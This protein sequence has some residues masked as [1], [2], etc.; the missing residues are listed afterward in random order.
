MCVGRSFSGPADSRL[1][2]LPFAA[3]NTPAE[4]RP[5]ALALEPCCWASV[6]AFWHVHGNRRSYELTKEV[7]YGAF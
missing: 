3:Y 5:E 6:I 1:P 2:D 7:M 4:T